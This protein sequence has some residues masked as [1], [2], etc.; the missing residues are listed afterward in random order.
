MLQWGKTI[1]PVA[2]GVYEANIDIM[3]A[4][5][6][7]G[8]PVVAFQIKFSEADRLTTYKV[9]SL[10]K[11]PHLLHTITGADEYDAKDMDLRGRNEIWT[12]D[13]LAVDDFEN[14]PLSSWDSAP[15]VVLR[16]E[17]Q[18]PIDVSSEF[19][20]Y[21][22]RQIAQLKSQLDPTALKEFRQSDGKLKSPAAYEMADLHSVIRTKIQVIEIVWMDLESG[23]EQQAWRDLADLW[24]PADVDRM[25]AAILAARAGGV[26]RQVDAASNPSVTLSFK[27]HATVFDCIKT[28]TYESAPESAFPGLAPEVKELA[29]T[30]VDSRPQPIYLGISYSKSQTQALPDPGTKIYLNLVIDAAGKV[31]SAELANKA[32]QGPVGDKV[33]SSSANWNFIPAFVGNRAVACRMNY[34][35]WPPQ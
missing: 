15:T 14:L 25:R 33:L 24:P 17:N 12:D 1:L 26:L 4:D 30:P 19:Q 10:A 3:G 35:V 6:G 28:D 22:D 32:D 29:P 11:P 2:H 34:G 27:R 9:F 20:P 18:R 8:Q 21:F 7:L 5:L 31:H 16:F 23:R 13:A